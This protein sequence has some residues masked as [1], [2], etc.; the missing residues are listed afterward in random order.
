[1]RVILEFCIDSLESAQ[2]IKECLPLDGDFRLE[3]CSNLTSGGG[4][5]PSMGLFRRIKAVLPGIPLMIM[6]RP[7]SG[8]FVYSDAEIDTMLG[9]IEAF[10]EE[11]GAK[12][13]VFGC[14][15]PEGT[16][17]VRNTKRLVKACDGYDVT[18]HR[19][20]D[21]TPDPIK[22]YETIAFI[23]GI[24]RILT[25]GHARSALEGVNTLCKLTELTQSSS[26]DPQRPITILPASGISHLNL[27]TLQEALPQT[28]E[29]HASCSGAWRPDTEDMTLSFER[30]ES[31]GFGLDEWKMD[32]TKLVGLWK[33]ANDDKLE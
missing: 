4:L 16:V 1:M 11:G 13:F 3:V 5:T 32:K 15:T 14:L 12:G 25:S 31:M 21:V 19:A 29:F 22:A 24:T 9:D 33:V 18:F 6:I 28:T 10:R 7:R 23:P 26:R 20:F 2:S 8:S 27:A 17:D 30:G